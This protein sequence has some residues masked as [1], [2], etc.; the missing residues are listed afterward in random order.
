MMGISTAHIFSS[1]KDFMFVCLGFW[2]EVVGNGYFNVYIY[3]YFIYLLV[4]IS[5]DWPADT[6]IYIC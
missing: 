2:W 5:V 3:K 6:H 1:L 4:S